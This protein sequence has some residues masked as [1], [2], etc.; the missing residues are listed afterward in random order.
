MRTGKS[1]FKSVGL[2]RS[3]LETLGLGLLLFGSIH[4]FNNDTQNS[5]FYNTSLFFDILLAFW[6]MIRLRIRD[7]KWIVKVAIDLPAALMLTLLTSLV[8]P[9]VFNLMG[10][11]LDPSATFGLFSLLGLTSGPIYIGFRIGRYFWAWWQRKRQHRLVWELIHIQLSLIALIAVLFI[12]AGII[13][14]NLSN[15]PQIS[16]NEDNLVITLASRLMETILPYMSV[17][18]VLTL[19]ALV[20]FMGPAALVSYLSVK[21]LTNRLDHLAQ[22]AQRLQQGDY[23]AR[24]EVQGEDEIAQLQRNFNA[25]ADDL[26]Y[27]FDALNEEKNKVS[28]LLE[29]RKQL[30]AN[31]SHELRT[32]VATIQSNLDSLSERDNLPDSIRQD[33]VILQNEVQHLTRLIDDLF[34]LSQAEVGALVIETKPVEVA[35]L[36]HQV[37]GAFKPLA[38]QSGKVMLVVEAQTDPIIEADP[39]RL[40]QVLANLIRN[41]IHHTP[42]GGIISLLVE[43]D[44]QTVRIHLRDTG[45]GISEEDLPHI[46]ERFYR[47]QGNPSTDQRGAG[48]GLSLVRELVNDM[49]GEISVSSQPGMGTTF[50]M[51]FNLR[52]GVHRETTAQ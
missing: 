35:S 9:L 6:L 21:R 37:A 8:I 5:L 32:P 24:A 38:W 17:T 1:G 11:Q 40:E 34:T 2:A 26:A 7:G 51:S 31:T 29:N 46:W 43:E 47:G 4:L 15:L 52:Q 48:L 28:L 12:L 25:M 3:L 23:Q 44:S 45:D 49:G 13:F 39:D 16:G 50:I 22:A 18:I 41:A 30:T 10:R 19:G 36:V 27:A 14:L 33:L 20:L 42:P